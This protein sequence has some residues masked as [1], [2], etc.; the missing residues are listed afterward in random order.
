MTDTPEGLRRWFQMSGVSRPLHTCIGPLP[1]TGASVVRWASDDVDGIEHA[2]CPHP[3]SYRI[4]VMLAP[5]EARIWSDQKPVWSGVI[6]A[7]RFRI[8]PPGEMGRWTRMSPCDIVNIFIPSQLFEQLHRQRGDTCAGQLQ[9]SPFMPD[10]VVLDLVTKMLDA[11]A[12]GGSLAA[13]LCDSLITALACYLIE[14]HTWPISR[15][16]LSGLGGVKL[17]RVLRHIA[18]SADATLSNAA[19][20]ALCGMSPA[21]FSREFHRAVGL[22]PHKFI[23]KCRLDRAAKM[24]VEGN[25]GILEI[26][27]DCGFASASHF[28]RVFS[29]HFGLSPNAFR[30]RYRKLN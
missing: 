27:Q 14:H 15:T 30:D 8:C 7:N 6:G 19:L 2:M 26:G 3:G 28:S 23:V 18:E 12:L 25:T 4:A 9:L 22:P 1:R 11:D 21:H 29:A 5:L 24:L 13:E 17:R 16:E 10:R 20:A